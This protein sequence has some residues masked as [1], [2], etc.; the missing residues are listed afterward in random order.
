[1]QQAGQRH[2]EG[3][4]GYRIDQIANNLDGSDSSG[5]DP[6]NGGFWFHKPAPPNI[7]LLQAGGKD[8]QTNFQISTPAERM[9]QLIGPIVADSTTSLLFVTSITPQTVFN[10]NQNQVLQTVNMQLRDVIVPKYESMGNNVFFVD[11]YSNF[12]DASGK[13]IH[14]ADG[15][16]PDQTGYN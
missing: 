12:V 13:I 1:L 7:I 10:A 11:Q 6:N 9:D 3:H 14:L 4:P 5:Y 16:H 2:H 15:V 8:I